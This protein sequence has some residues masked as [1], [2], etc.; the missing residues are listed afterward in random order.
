MKH[1]TILGY[2]ISIN[3][4]KTIPVLQCM[5]SN[6]TIKLEVS[7][8]RIKLEVKTSLEFPHILESQVKHL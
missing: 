1:L 7:N 8:N 6:N 2:N 4:L 3:K 5:L